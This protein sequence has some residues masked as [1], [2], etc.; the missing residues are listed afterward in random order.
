MYC[1]GG[2]FLI[3]E[4]FVELIVDMYRVVGIYIGIVCQFDQ[5]VCV[6]ELDCK[7]G[8]KW[9]VDGGFCDQIVVILGSERVWYGGQVCCYFDVVG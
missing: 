5:L 3:L 6:F 8:V 9:L 4:G 7:F 1:F 2:K